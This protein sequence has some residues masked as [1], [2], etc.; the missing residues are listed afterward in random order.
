MERP[1]VLTIA[2][3][4]PSGGAGL[5]SDIKTMESIGVQ[6]LSV[7][8]ANTLQTEDDFYELKWESPEWIKKQVLMLCTR[9]K[10]SFAKI[11]IIQDL[12]IL[13]EVIDLLKQRDIKVIWDPVLKS[14]TYFE[15]QR[16]WDKEQLRQVIYKI[17]LIT[18]NKLEYE[19]R[20]KHILNPVQHNFLLKGGHDAVTDE[21]KDLLYYNGNKA[22]F[23]QQRIPSEKHGTGCILSSAIA[24]YLALGE[25]MESAVDKAKVYVT[26]YLK[27]D[28]SKLGVHHAN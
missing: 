28:K 16:E 2:G 1:F 13:N 5:L 12:T 23:A 14:S 25:P 19:E 3:F 7:L 9:Y 26:D 22:I 24:S 6:G 27:S 20:F 21:V 11:G 15:I 17:E 18:P 4:D 8:T 10:F